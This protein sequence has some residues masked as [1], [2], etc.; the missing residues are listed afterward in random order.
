M[1]ELLFLSVSVR[2]CSRQGYLSVEVLNWGHWIGFAF[3]IKSSCHS[4]CHIPKNME[5]SFA[6]DPSHPEGAVSQG[7]I[8]WLKPPTMSNPEYWVPSRAA[9]VI[10]FVVSDMTQQ[11]IKP[12]ITQSQGINSTTKPLSWNL[13][14]LPS[15]PKDFWT[16]IKK[17]FWMRGETSPRYENQS[18]C[19][20][21]NPLLWSWL[22]NFSKAG[23]CWMCKTSRYNIISD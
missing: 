14:H 22:S 23:Q 17:A 8:G 5:L 2:I 12:K 6:L 3:L 11:R 9:I 4:K 15:Q 1:L 16:I 7:I 20:N 13:R 21:L 18:R 19:L 10:I